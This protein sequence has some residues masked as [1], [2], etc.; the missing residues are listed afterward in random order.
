MEVANE[1]VARL[2][3][4]GTSRFSARLFHFASPPLWKYKAEESWYP[5]FLEDPVFIWRCRSARVMAESTLL[6]GIGAGRGCLCVKI[7]SGLWD[8]YK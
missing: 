5:L 6:G 3:T 2:S 8:F 4:A 7:Q 1:S